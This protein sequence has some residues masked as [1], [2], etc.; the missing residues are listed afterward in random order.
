MEQRA[1][2]LEEGVTL[3]IDRVEISLAEFEQEE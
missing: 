3:D 2:S 1:S